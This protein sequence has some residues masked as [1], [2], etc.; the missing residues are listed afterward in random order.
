MAYPSTVPIPSA[1]AK[2]VPVPQAYP[3]TVPVPAAQ[4]AGTPP[5]PPPPPPKPTKA[6]AKAW[7]NVSWEPVDWVKSTSLPRTNA[8]PAEGRQLLDQFDADRAQ[9]QKDMAARLETR[10]QALIKE[11]EA[12]QEQYTKAGKLD[13]AI[14]VRNYLR[15][16]KG[17]GAK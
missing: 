5:P 15:A 14:A 12:L 7:E 11:L 8:L 2:P 16:V 17:P 10:R 9:I 3:A 4:Q 13:E 1:L 6:P